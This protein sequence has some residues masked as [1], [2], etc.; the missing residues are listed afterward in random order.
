M[1]HRVNHLPPQLSV[2]ERQRVAVARALA[3]DPKILLADE[4]TGNLDSRNAQQVLDLFDRLHRER[5]M[6]MVVV[7]HGQD[8]AQRA[9]HIIRLR[10]GR[11]EDDGPG[12]ASP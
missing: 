10:D 8:V 11:V 4:P 3:N 5:Q 7:T 9:Q 1:S 6:T 12:A 2:G